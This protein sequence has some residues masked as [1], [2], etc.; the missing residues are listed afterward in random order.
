MIL[1]LQLQNTLQFVKFYCNGL[2]TALI[3][4]HARISSIIFF[5]SD[6]Y[7]FYRM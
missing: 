3:Y 4:F 2:I 7:I 6:H 1:I 5:I